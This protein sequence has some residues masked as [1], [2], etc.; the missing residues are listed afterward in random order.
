M[1]VTKATEKV[2][3]LLNQQLHAAKTQTERSKLGQFATPFSLATEILEY[4]RKL[5]PSDK[6]IRFLDP[7][8]GLAPFTS[9]SATPGQI[10]SLPAA[11]EHQV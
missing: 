10:A 6:K 9:T 2:R 3:M 11:L 1:T 7:D 4:A 5:L 8:E